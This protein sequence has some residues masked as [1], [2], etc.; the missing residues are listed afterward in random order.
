M[1]FVKKIFKKSDGNPKD[2]TFSAN[3]YCISRTDAFIRYGKISASTIQNTAIHAFNMM[4]L[5][6]IAIHEWIAFYCYTF[7]ILFYCCSFCLELDV[8]ML[9]ELLMLMVLFLRL[10][11][12]GPRNRIFFRYPVS[13]N[14]LSFTLYTQ[15]RRIHLP[16]NHK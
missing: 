2:T 10:S 15:F 11:F 13:R 5:C 4:K 9:C 1:L 16:R 12:V 8:P 14:F 3:N 7:E 6:R